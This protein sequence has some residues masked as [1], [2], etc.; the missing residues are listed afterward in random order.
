LRNILFEK[1]VNLWRLNS[2]RIFLIFVNKTR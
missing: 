1:G 2:N